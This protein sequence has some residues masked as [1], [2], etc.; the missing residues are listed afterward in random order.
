MVMAKQ[1]KAEE[2]KVMDTAE[3]E[4]ENES[5]MEGMSVHVVVPHLR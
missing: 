5:V 3:S 4:R 1:N 2:T